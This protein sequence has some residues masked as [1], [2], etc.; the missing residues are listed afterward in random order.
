MTDQTDV[1]IHSLR[2]CLFDQHQ[3]C[4]KI[5]ESGVEAT[6]G[7][8]RI[9]DYFVTYT[10]LLKAMRREKMRTKTRG[11]PAKG[12]GTTIGVR[13]TSLCLRCWTHIGETNPIFRRGPQHCGAWRSS[14]LKLQKS[15]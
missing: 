2:G 15:R 7:D 5:I 9:T 11:R 14:R 13:V 8:M 4:E 6:I 12:P 1:D 10:L 3:R